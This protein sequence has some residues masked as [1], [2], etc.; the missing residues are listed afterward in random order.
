MKPGDQRCIDRPSQKK[1]KTKMETESVKRPGKI[2]KKKSRQKPVAE[3][4]N[5]DGKVTG[6]RRQGERSR[7]GVIL[8]RR[9]R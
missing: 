5:R 2:E 4:H 1:K 7:D 3:R 8:R 6:T 9:N